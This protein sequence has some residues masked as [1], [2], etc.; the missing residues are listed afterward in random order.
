MN[1]DKHEYKKLYLKYK[2]KY[3][4]LKS[5]TNQKGGERNI[6]DIDIEY[7][8]SQLKLNIQNSGQNNCGIVFVD[9]KYVI[10]C[11]KKTKIISDDDHREKL[12]D[13]INN[14]LD[15]LF[16][17]YYAWNNNNNKYIKFIKISEENEEPLYAKCTMMEKLDGDFTSYVLKESYRQAFGN[18]DEY[19][20]YYDRLRKTHEYINVNNENEVNKNKFND[21]I[22]KIK[23]NIYNLCLSLNTK[24]TFL[25]HKLAKLG[26]QYHDLKLDNIGYKITDGQLK[27]YFIDEESGLQ[28][29]FRDN[30][31]FN[32]NEYVELEFLKRVLG[33]Y[34][35]LG[36]Q[37]MRSQFQIEFGHFENPFEDENVITTITN[38]KDPMNHQSTQK[39][40]MISKENS[41]FKWIHVRCTGRNNSAII[42]YVHGLY[43]LVSFDDNLR[44]ISNKDYDDR[45]KKIDMLCY[46]LNEVCHHL[47]YLFD[48]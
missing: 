23:P 25:H 17:K 5:L 3:N 14:D 4:N 13:D 48:V 44:H 12:Y 10:K 46:S 33:K 29:I 31:Y 19:D 47:Y 37:N 34:D 41:F 22:N 8:V 39:N 35:F 40:I 38:L 20:F 24:L 2:Q 6:V 18:L 42:Q 16:P 26:W 21:A 45:F 27:L 15:G 43:R 28:K 1:V 7:V 30:Q 36:Q 11:V 9:D 32:V